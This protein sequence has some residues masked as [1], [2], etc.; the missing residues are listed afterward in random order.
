MYTYLRDYKSARLPL[1]FAY[2]TRRHCVTGV[3]SSAVALLYCFEWC[4]LSVILDSTSSR[5]TRKLVRPPVIPATLRNK[6]CKLSAISRKRYTT[7]GRFFH[8]KN[9][10]YLR[11]KRDCDG[12]WILCSA[13]IVILGRSLEIHFQLRTDKN[14]FPIVLFYLHAYYLY[15][16]MSKE[17]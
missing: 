7:T 10:S 13:P 4:T 8:E 14:F 2:G 1:F 5:H 16:L 12:S 6:T 3:F 15:I 11:W 17:N 9:S